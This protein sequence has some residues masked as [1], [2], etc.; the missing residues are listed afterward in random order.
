MSRLTLAALFAAV[1]LAGCQTA[2]D[3]VACPKPPA[4]REEA[5][6]KAPV[7]E[8]VQI[9]QPGHWD[10]DG[11]TYT[12]V[13]GRWIRRDSQSGQWMNGYWDRPVIPG[14]CVWNPAHW[15]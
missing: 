15:V 8:Y 11:R 5:I 13:D 2:E 10:W 4:S 14:P 1:L 9:Y 3:T 12:W 6:P 7:Q